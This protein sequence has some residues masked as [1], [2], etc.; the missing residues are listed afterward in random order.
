MTRPFRRSVGILAGVLLVGLIQA[1]GP[2]IVALD[3]RPNNSSQAENLAYSVASKANCGSLEALDPVGTR[4]KW[5]FACQTSTTSYTIEVFGS[6]ESRRS[7]LQSLRDGG[8]PYV[9]KGYYAVS[10]APNAA[11]KEEALRAS[12]PPSLLDLF[13]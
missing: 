8:Q 5:G 6:D 1:C 12:P 7:G 11:T 4:E 10:V 9:A 13:R 2:S 3:T